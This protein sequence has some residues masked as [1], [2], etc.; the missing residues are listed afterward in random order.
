[1][2]NALR[3]AWSKL[4]STRHHNEPKLRIPFGLIKDYIAG[5]DVLKLLKLLALLKEQSAVAYLAWVLRVL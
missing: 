2:G 5:F 3:L 4:R 1:M